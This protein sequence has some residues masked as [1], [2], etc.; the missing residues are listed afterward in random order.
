VKDIKEFKYKVLERLDKRLSN[1]N[2]VSKD[3]DRVNSLIR[4]LTTVSSEGLSCLGSIGSLLEALRN[5][6]GEEAFKSL[7]R[8]TEFIEKLLDVQEEAFKEFVS[9]LRG[10]I[11]LSKKHISTKKMI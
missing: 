11:F 4:A 2:I 8:N 9:E 1:E 6:E 3:Y 10:E 5:K 7:E